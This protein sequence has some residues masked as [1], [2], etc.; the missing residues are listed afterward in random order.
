MRKGETLP[1]DKNL[2]YFT[3][4][5]KKQDLGEVYKIERNYRIAPKEHFN[6]QKYIKNLYS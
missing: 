3:A 6:P 1:E 5:L 2:K 4:G